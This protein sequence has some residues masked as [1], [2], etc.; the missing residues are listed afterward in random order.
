MYIYVVLFC[1]VLLNK[2]SRKRIT[3][4]MLNFWVNQTMLFILTFAMTY[5]AFSLYLEVRLCGF[6][7]GKETLT[8]KVRAQQATWHLISNMVGVIKNYKLRTFDG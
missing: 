1:F 6:P 7:V 2:G 8:E 3:P 4:V 5:D